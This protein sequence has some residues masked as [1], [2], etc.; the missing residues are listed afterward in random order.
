MSMCDTPNS[1]SASTTAFIT[2]GS[3]P[4]HPAPATSWDA[5]AYKPA[6]AEP[7][8]PPTT[9]VAE[10]SPPPAIEPLQPTPVPAPA[11]SPVKHKPKA[12]KV[13]KTV[14]KPSPDQVAS[15]R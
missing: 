7:V 9:A 4:A 1:A 11:P 5:A 13:V 2:A 6:P 14:K 3:E 8:V 15:S 12:K 10:T